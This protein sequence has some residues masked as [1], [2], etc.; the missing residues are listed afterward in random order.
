MPNNIKLSQE[1]DLIQKFKI[2]NPENFVKTRK[3]FKEQIRLDED[4]FSK[5]H[6]EK[7]INYNILSIDG[8]DSQKFLFLKIGYVEKNAKMYFFRLQ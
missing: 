4:Y 5:M 7:K 1:S 8:G 3:T 6:N 2:L